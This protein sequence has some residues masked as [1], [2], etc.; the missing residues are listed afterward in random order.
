MDSR[1]ET[2]RANLE[3]LAA[4]HVDAER[5]RNEATTRLQLIDRLFFECLGWSRETDVELE[6]SQ[7]GEYADYTFSAPRRIMIVEAKREG[8]YFEVPA[9]DNRL[10]VKLATIC[11]D[12]ADLKAA[13]EQAMGYCQRRGVPIGVVANGHQLMAFLAVRTDGI[14]PM[15]GQVLVFPSFQFM[16]THF[17]RLWQGLSRPGMKRSTY[18]RN[19]WA[20][21]SLSFRPSSRRRFTTIP[22]SRRVISFRR[23][24]KS[25]RS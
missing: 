3:L 4:Y 18:K 14:A 9:G 23:T 17:L 8:K 7:D 19:S 2:C 1:Y 22:G 25:W 5:D 20:T 6:Q 13:V 24:S 21:H 11:R 16:S 10:I 15:E 12:N